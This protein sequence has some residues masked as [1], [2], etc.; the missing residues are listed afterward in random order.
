MFRSQRKSFWSMPGRE[1]EDCAILL[2]DGAGSDVRLMG[3]TCRVTGIC[4]GASACCRTSFGGLAAGLCACAAG[5]LPGREKSPGMLEGR[6]VESLGNWYGSSGPSGA[7]EAAAPPCWRLRAGLPFSLGV[8]TLSYR[9]MMA[10]VKTSRNST[11]TRA[12]VDA[13]TPAWCQAAMASQEMRRSWGGRSLGSACLGGACS[14]DESIETFVASSTAC[15]SATMAA[16][17]AAA[18]WAS[19][20]TAPERLASTATESWRTEVNSSSSAVAAPLPVKELAEEAPPASKLAQVLTSPAWEQS[21]SAAAQTS[22]KSTGRLA[23][24]R[25][26]HM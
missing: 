8:L 23:Q 20:A 24:G 3:L 2:G 7:L 12:R 19:G 9:M 4:S 21:V 15:V 16:S 5:M 13:G 14:L 10:P 11:T 26:L 6:W 1:S 22:T 17:C 25:A 18:L